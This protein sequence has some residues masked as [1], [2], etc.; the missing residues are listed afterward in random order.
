MKKKDKTHAASCPHAGQHTAP[1]LSA[2]LTNTSCRRGL[3]TL[4]GCGPRRL[5]SI[6]SRQVY[7]AYLCLRDNLSQLGSLLFSVK[8]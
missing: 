5:L 4:W 6:G 1:P 7:A 8:A 2:R 3:Q